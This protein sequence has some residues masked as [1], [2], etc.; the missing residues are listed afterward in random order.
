[1]LIIVL[2]RVRNLKGMVWANCS[3]FVEMLFSKWYNHNL[4]CNPWANDPVMMSHDVILKRRNEVQ[5]SCFYIIH[6]RIPLPGFLHAEKGLWQLKTCCPDHKRGQHDKEKKKPRLESHRWN[7]RNTHLCRN[8]C[9]YMMSL[10]YYPSPSLLL[11]LCA[12]SHTSASAASYSRLPK[13][14][15]VNYEIHRC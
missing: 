4:T 8:V 10:W 15:L 14:K 12:Y 13:C 1:M 9:T 7:N 6:S 3:N 5:C 11:C 2:G